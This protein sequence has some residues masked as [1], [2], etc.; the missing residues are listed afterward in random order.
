MWHNG[1]SL[2]NLFKSC[3]LPHMLQPAVGASF[4]IGCDLFVDNTNQRCNK[5]PICQPH[6]SGF[7][8]MMPL[9]HEDLCSMPDGQDSCGA[10]WARARP[11]FA[12]KKSQQWEKGFDECK[13][14]YG[15]GENDYVPSDDRGSCPSVT[16]FGVTS[17][18]GQQ[19]LAELQSAAPARASEAFQ[20]HWTVSSSENSTVSQQAR[21]ARMPSYLL[22]YYYY[23]WNES[24]ACS[25]NCCQIFVVFITLVIGNDQTY[26]EMIRNL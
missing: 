6:C 18:T 20:V 23:C 11:G 10:I 24:V 26:F 9:M 25:E 19:Q 17:E 12:P 3:T 2:L 15:S 16:V 14:R 21:V 4:D 8:Q 7:C 22:R 13:R 1:S 5:A